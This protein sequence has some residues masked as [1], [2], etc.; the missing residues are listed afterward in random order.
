[1]ELYESPSSDARSLCDLD[2]N[3]LN[4]LFPANGAVDVDGP[5]VDVDTIFVDD[6]KGARVA[7]SAFG[8][9]PT[10]RRFG[11][12]SLSRADDSTSSVSSFRLEAIRFSS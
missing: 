10:F 11:V 2:G 3:F 9:G 5:G 1:M 12:G 4:A 8:F 6:V 7:P